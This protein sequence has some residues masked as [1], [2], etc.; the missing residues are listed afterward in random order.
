MIAG[1][2]LLLGLTVSAE[3]EVRVF[4]CEPEWAALAHEVGGSLVSA[5]S[6]THAAQDPHYIRARPSL[7]SA[8]RRADLMICSGA[9]LEVGWLPVLMQKAGNSRVAPG[10]PGHLMVADFVPLL[11]QGGPADR[12]EGDV[13]P[14]GNPHTHLNP[15]N[16]LAI[17]GVL[18]E[19]LSEID[20]GNAPAYAASHEAFQTRWRSA[21]E[22]WEAAAEPLRGARIVTHHKSWS[23]LIDWLGLELVDTVEPKPGIPPT[24]SHLQSLLMAVEAAPVHAILRTAY[25]PEDGAEWL[26]ERSG[27]PV[28]VPPYTIGGS[29]RSQTLEALFDETLELLLEG[30]R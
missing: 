20:P 7:I 17:A 10:A 30:G 18:K 22:R 13:H 2:G 24:A 26:S 3:A 6:A 11:E 14:E 12:S 27:L 16:L 15:H 5:S 28:L 23:Y 29:D 4:A 21:I 8:M 9:G 25:D 19:R 1:A